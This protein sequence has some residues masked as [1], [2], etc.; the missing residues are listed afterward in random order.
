MNYLQT[1]SKIVSMINFCKKKIILY[2]RTL[3]LF[4]HAFLRPN[5]PLGS[6]H[7]R[8]MAQ[9]Y[10]Y[11]KKAVLKYFLRDLYLIQQSVV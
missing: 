8:G 4:H 2:T 11:F 5:W 3:S 10:Y 1:Y 9:I 7:T 6:K